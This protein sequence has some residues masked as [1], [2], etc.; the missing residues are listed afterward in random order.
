[1]N[2]A[3]LE[4]LVTLAIHAAKVIADTSI[5]YL[6]DIGRADI[7]ASEDS[8]L[9]LKTAIEESTGPMMKA[10]HAAA[11]EASVTDG[12]PVEAFETSLATDTE[13][14]IALALRILDARNN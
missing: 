1:M 6:T 8:L 2:A 11:R 9:L 3:R 4:M 7:L 12:D 10:A 14:T 5:R 13:R